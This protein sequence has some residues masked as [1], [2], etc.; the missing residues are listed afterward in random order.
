[1]APKWPEPSWKS[2][3]IG[4]SRSWRRTRRARCHGETALSRSQPASMA[5]SVGPIGPISNPRPAIRAPGFVDQTLA[6]L[7]KDLTAELRNRTAVSSILL[8]TLTALVVIGFALGGAG[9][10]PAMRGALVWVVL[11]F[12][13]FSGLAHVFIHEEEAGTSVALRLTA[14]S[15]AVYA[16]KLLFNLLV[17]G[18]I[19]L[20]V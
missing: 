2:S 13:A 18:G 17:L 20:V 6:V 1:M 15:G 5:E 19:A 10:E 4:A 16:G 8:F 12:A 3:G 11:F 14:S 7:A 9:L